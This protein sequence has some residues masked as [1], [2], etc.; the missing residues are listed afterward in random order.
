[1]SI[2]LTRDD[3]AHLRDVVAML[4]Q[5]RDRHVTLY[6]HYYTYTGFGSFT[7]VLGRS[8]RRVKLAFDGKENILNV[9]ASDFGNAN[10]APSWETVPQKKL[11]C[12][13]DVRHRSG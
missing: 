4:D 7:I 8:H 13:D 3:I 12:R 9:S 10:S 11:S 6:E 1:M 2:G 5:L